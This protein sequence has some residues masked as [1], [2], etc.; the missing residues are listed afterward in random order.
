MC[1]TACN[2]QKI[3]MEEYGKK[4]SP[5]IAIMKVAAGGQ[6]FKGLVESQGATDHL[7]R[8]FTASSHIRIYNLFD[9]TCAAQY[10][11]LGTSGLFDSGEKKKEKY[12]RPEEERLFFFPRP[13]NFVTVI[14]HYLGFII[15]H[16]MDR[17]SSQ[18]SH[19]CSKCFDLLENYV[20]RSYLYGVKSVF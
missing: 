10:M 11:L 18:H 20:N 16:S 19:C 13:H 4:G 5:V 17:H 15:S 6:G 9:N 8:P 12:M 3:E 14:C 2:L 1:Y 7:K